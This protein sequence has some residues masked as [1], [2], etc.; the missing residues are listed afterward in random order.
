MQKQRSLFE[1]H[2]VLIASNESNFRTLRYEFAI[3]KKKNMKV[4]AFSFFKKKIAGFLTLI[5][6]IILTTT[7]QSDFSLIEFLNSFRVT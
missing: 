5:L 1:F 3:S 2:K 6:I 4:I 7:Q